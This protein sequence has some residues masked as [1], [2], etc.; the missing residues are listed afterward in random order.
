MSGV[1]GNADRDGLTA[2]T[3]QYE[4][5]PSSAAKFYFE[6]VSGNQFKVY[7]MNGESSLY[8][9]MTR[10][11]GNASRGGITLTADENEATP[12][13]ITKTNTGNTFYF[14]ATISGT[15]FYWNRN[16]KSPGA[17]AFVGYASST[18]KNTAR[19]ALEYE[20]ISQD[21]PYE[22]DGKSY[23]LM[24]CGSGI[25]AIGLTDA[26]ITK[27]DT[28]R[29]G[30]K[31]MLIRNDP[32]DQSRTL[33]ISKDADLAVWTF[34]NIAEDRYYISCGGK[35][36]SIDGANISLVD[37]PDDNCVPAG[38]RRRQT[39]GQGPSVRRG[40]QPRGELQR[41]CERRLYARR[42]VRQ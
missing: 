27:N 34:Q 22:L 2:T 19:I 40:G 37:S 6:R 18:D 5:F 7:T 33:F 3:D 25:S 12:I 26:L 9:K 14:S 23:S 32:M 42:S 20:R 41:K 24:N 21:D 11:S 10:V 28:T 15:T 39:R 13:T 16:E 17:G 8:V 1:T 29:L 30:A 38:A 31:Q 36:L 35:Y 4:S